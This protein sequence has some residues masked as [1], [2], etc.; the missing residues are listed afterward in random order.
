LPCGRAH[1]SRAVGMVRNLGRLAQQ[2]GMADPDVQSHIQMAS[3]EIEG[4]WQD[5]WTPEKIA[6]SPPEEQAILERIVPRLRA[7][8][9]HLEAARTPSEL[10]QVVDELAS[11]NEEFVRMDQG[12]S[13]RSDT[14]AMIVATEPA[15][16]HSHRILPPS[17]LY[18]P[19]STETVME[20]TAPPDSAVAFDNLVRALGDRGVRVRWRNLQATPE[21]VLEG[22]YVFGTNTILLGAATLARDPY[23]VQVLAHEAAHA[24]ADNPAC[25]T[26]NEEVPYR[27]RPEERLAQSASLIAMLEDGLPVEL[28]DGSELA[29]GDRRVDWDG[30]R[31]AMAPDDYARLLWTSA[32]IADA[33]DGAPRDY[34]AVSCPPTSLPA[35]V[36][37]RELRA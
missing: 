9:E 17:W 22:Q 6:A 29:P 19:P 10:Q 3:E 12:R 36:T 8:H 23:A 26:Y 2:R 34:R 28:Q 16:D 5:D 7:V 11:V 13:T 30:L 27:E 1:L 25:H 4:L 20:A 21:G 24:L 15:M 14:A 31:A 18:E 33:M 37:L 35:A 32:W